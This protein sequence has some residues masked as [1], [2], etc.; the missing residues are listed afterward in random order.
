LAVVL[1]LPWLNP[2]ALGPSPNVQPLLISW[3]SAA[4]TLGLV[5][6]GRVCSAVLWRAAVWAWVAAAVLSAVLGLV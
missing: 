6:V 5:A 1:A 2:F 3:A 4:L